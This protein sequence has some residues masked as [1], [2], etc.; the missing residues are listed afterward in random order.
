M[1][2]GSLVDLAVE[3]FTRAEWVSLFLGLTGLYWLV[4]GWHGLRLG[5]TRGFGWGEAEWTG[6]DA[7]LAGWVWTGVGCTLLLVAGAVWALKA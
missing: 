2:I 5:H 3:T 6:A 4:L 7:R 1:N